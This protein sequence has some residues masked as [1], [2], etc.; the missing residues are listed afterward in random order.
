MSD[1]K[2]KEYPVWSNYVYFVTTA[3]VAG[4]GIRYRKIEFILYSIIILLSGIFSIVYHKHTPSYTGNR[5][6]WDNK[7]FKLWSI[8]DQVFAA[9]VV[10]VSIFFFLW[11][12]WVLKSFFPFMYSN[13]FYLSILFIILSS[14]FFVLGNEHH[15]SAKECNKLNCF[16]IQL[17]SYDIFHSNWHIFTSIGL[18]FWTNVLLFSYQL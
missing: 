11:R 13:D 12:A 5:A 1:H 9:L 18:I 10:V 16:D 17:D 8:L 6:T 15:K 14:I 3:Y 4:I 7:H 2:L